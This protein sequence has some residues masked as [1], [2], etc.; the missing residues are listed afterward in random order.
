[1]KEEQP[2]VSVIVPC[3]NH[4]HYIR[5]CVLSIL[6]QTYTNI[7][8]IVIDDGSSDNS[9]GILKELA[10]EYGFFVEQQQNMGLSATLNKGINRYAK[11]KYVACVAS[12][13]YWQENKV[14]K[15]VAVLEKNPDMAFLFSRTLVVDNDGV[16]KAEIPAQKHISCTFDALLQG[17]FIPA[18]TVLMRRDV[19]LETGGYDESSYIEDWDMWLRIADKHKFGF[20]DEHL[21]Y[22]RLHGANMSSRAFKMIKAQQIILHKWKGKSIYKKAYAKWAITSYNILAGA[23]KQFT[24]LQLLTPSLRYIHTTAFHKATFKLFFRWR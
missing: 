6:N 23:E 22:Y 21:A 12:D 16:T 9:Y 10:E 13:D 8:L 7:Q 1:M 20:I 2:L 15:Q 5:Q 17:S 18:L 3:Y 4:E 11:G 19:F 14:A 24:I